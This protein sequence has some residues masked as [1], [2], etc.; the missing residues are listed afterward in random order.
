MLLDLLSDY[1]TFTKL[2][3]C[4]NNKDTIILSDTLLADYTQKNPDKAAQLSRK[5]AAKLPENWDEINNQ[6]LNQIYFQI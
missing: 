4:L 3:S 5:L 6:W 1:S 2:V